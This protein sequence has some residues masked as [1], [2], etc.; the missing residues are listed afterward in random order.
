[1]TYSLCL[2]GMESW[3]QG[4]QSLVSSTMLPTMV[5]HIWLIC[6]RLFVVDIFALVDLFALVELWNADVNCEIFG[7]GPI[8]WNAIVNC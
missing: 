5:K 7:D 3:I 4:C 6:C 1:M 8:L 2:Q